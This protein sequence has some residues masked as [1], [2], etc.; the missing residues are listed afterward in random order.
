MTASRVQNHATV[1]LIC[2]LLVIA[3]LL[4]WP[5]T[6]ESA[7]PDT[8]DN[9]I[10]FL[11]ADKRLQKDA[12]ALVM[13]YESI[14]GAGCRKPEVSDR[15]IAEPPDKPGESVWVEKWTLN[16]CGDDVYYMIT[17]T[18]TPSRGGTDIS[19][20]PPESAKD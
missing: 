3:S 7:N 15:E 12:K 9:Q 10:V 4:C 16:R 6:I 18:P 20:A 11:G 17:F 14:F 5:I 13:V 8:S 1:T 19:V 2:A